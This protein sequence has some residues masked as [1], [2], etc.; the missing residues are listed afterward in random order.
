MWEE[1]LCK[2][3]YAQKYGG[4]L[5]IRMSRFIAG[6]VMSIKEWGELHEEMNYL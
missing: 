6:H 3:S 2:R 4:H 1:Q 5:C